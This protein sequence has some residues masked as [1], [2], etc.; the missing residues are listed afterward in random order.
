[1]AVDPQALEDPAARRTTHLLKKIIGHISFA[2][3]HLPFRKHARL[4][5]ITNEKCQMIYDQ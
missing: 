1:M 3:S 5:S 4:S 2:I